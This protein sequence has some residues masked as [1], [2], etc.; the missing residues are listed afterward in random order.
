MARAKKMTAAP[1][2][3]SIGH[4]VFLLGVFIAI[5]AGFLAGSNTTIVWVLAVLGLLVGLLNLQMSETHGFLV[6]TLVLVVS[7]GSLN[8]LPVIGSTLG[9]ILQYIVIF[10]AP[11]ALVVALKAVYNFASRW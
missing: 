7:A 1:G 3:E 2:L 4:W 6:A 10:V 11:A 8:V 5:V 9:V